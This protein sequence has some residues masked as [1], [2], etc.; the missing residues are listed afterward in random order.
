MTN[1][2]INT[3][4]PISVSSGGTGSSSFTNT[5]GTAIYNGTNLVSISPGTLGQVL[6]SNGTSAPSFQTVA[7]SGE[8]ILLQTVTANNTSSSATLT[9]FSNSYN[10]YA[11]V[12]SNLLPTASLS[13]TQLTMAWSTDGGS[14]YL[15]SYTGGVIGWPVN[16]GSPHGALASTNIPIDYAALPTQSS[17][18]NVGYGATWYLYN[19]SANSADIYPTIVG[20]GI[21]TYASGGS[22]LNL[23]HQVFSATTSTNIIINALQLNLSSGN[24]VSGSVSLYALVQ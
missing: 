16:G 20:Q 15:G 17:G 2:A 5:Y 7:G 12:A 22:T 1:S 3:T 24:F 23:F 14:T 6:L 9:A 10:T 4:D 18:V 21:R 8:W 19:M 13:S 11:M